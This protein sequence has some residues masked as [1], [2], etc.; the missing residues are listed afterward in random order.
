VKDKTETEPMKTRHLIAAL[1]LATAAVPAAG[2]DLLNVYRDAVVS[3]PVFQA[4]RSQRNATIERLPQAR[5]GYL[6]FIAGSASAFRNITERDG[7]PDYDYSTRAASVTLSQPIFRLPNWIAIS[8][9]E[10]IVVQADARLVDAGQELIVRVAQAY[11]DVLLAQDNV[12]LSGAQKEAFTQQLAQAKRN[13]EVGTA[14]IVDTLEAQARYDQTI[15]K[16]ILDQND[17]EVKRRALEQLVGKPIDGLVPLRE[18]LVL[19]PPSPND[20][21]AWVNAAQDSSLAVIS[22]KAFAEAAKQEVDRVRAG[23]LPT[24]DLSANYGVARNPSTVLGQDVSATGRA[25]QVGIVIG[26]PIFEG[27]LTQ[28]RVREAVALRDKATQDLDNTQRTVAQSVR[29]FFLFVTNGISGVQ[30]LERALASTQSQLESTILGRDVGVRTSVDVLNAQQQVIQTR[31]DLQQVRYGYLMNTLRLK[32]AA[33][34]LSEP[35]LEII[36]RTLGRG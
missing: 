11:F 17:L 13:F 22:A 26:V 5:A 12:A 10:K 1:A 32:A 25:G 31:R 21:E 9:A 19:V 7:T 18:G 14:T 30:A 20:I 27:G 36:N 4:A 28:S 3:D 24:V 6:P 35:D 23:H 15:A 34:R 16:E 29:Q 8:Q 2:A 33:G